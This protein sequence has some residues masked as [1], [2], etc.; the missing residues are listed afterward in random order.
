MGYGASGLAID[1]GG[2]RADVSPV[3]PPVVVEAEERV[4]RGIVRPA[5]TVAASADIAPSTQP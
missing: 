5:P 1:L 4:E 3:R 2:H